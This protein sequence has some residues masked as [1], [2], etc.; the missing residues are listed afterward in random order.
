MDDY[1]STP[2]TS[3]YEPAI[4]IDAWVWVDGLTGSQ[5]DIVSIDDDWLGITKDAG[6]YYFAA[7]IVD[8]TTGEITVLGSTPVQP[9]TWYH[10]AMRTDDDPE[11]RL[12]INGEQVD[13]AG[14]SGSPMPPSG[15]F[16]IG[17]GNPGGGLTHFFDGIIDE[18]EIFYR[19]LSNSEIQAIYDAG[20]A[21]KCKCLQPAPG[22]VSW[23][24]G[25]GN[26]KDIVGNNHGTLINS[27]SY[28]NNGLVGPAFNFGGGGFVQV[29]DSSSLNLASALTLNAWVQ[30][31]NLSVDYM[32]IIGKD[33]E[34][35]GGYRSYLLN[36]VKDG[37]HA[38][39]RAHL[40][41]DASG[42]VYIDGSTS[43]TVGPWYH[44]AMTYDGAALRL[45]VNGIE[46]NSMPVT[47]SIQANDGPFRIGGG[48]PPGE[49]QLYFDGL[50]D[51]VQLHDIALSASDIQAIYHYRVLGQCK[52]CQIY[53]PLV[54]KN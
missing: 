19:A 27:V 53:L 47:G 32:D 24:P 54:R 6:S 13:S 46:D 2:L 39:F 8:I 30:V 35:E 36:A 28:V 10:V 4:T 3:I 48:A 29:P 9:H 50:I 34:G 23:W 40:T 33:P 31:S 37:D 42:F 44:V 14:I 51:E 11:L 17:A 16:L 20:P 15:N 18:V 5:M 49:A 7:H 45:F 21:G 22:L 38:H 1:V 26:S 25:D 43:V 41:T 12:L 52:H